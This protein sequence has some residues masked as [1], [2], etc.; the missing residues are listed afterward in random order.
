MIFIVAL[1][2]ASGCAMV[3]QQIALGLFSAAYEFLRARD[4]DAALA[5]PDTLEWMQNGGWMMGLAAG[6]LIFWLWHRGDRTLAARSNS[7]KRWTVLALGGAGAAQ[8]GYQTGINLPMP[9]DIIRPGTTMAAGTLTLFV[10]GCVVL[11]RHY[12]QG[13]STLA[14]IG[15]GTLTGM[16]AIVIIFA[17][18]ASNKYLHTLHGSSGEASAVWMEIEF[19]PNA[20]AADK[21]PDANKI[22]VA[23]RTPE[24]MASGFASEWIHNGR[25]LSLRA[26]IDLQ[27]RNRDRVVTLTPPEG[28][29]LTFRMPLPA[30]PA[31]MG[32][33]D[34]WRR[35]DF[36]G[37]TPPERHTEYRIRFMVTP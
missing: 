12:D 34:A 35:I 8:I 3:G 9:I 7:W 23:L 32:N 24:G 19:P 26:N 18:L 30:N 27:A 6:A 11:T 37:D 28:P 15:H 4:L 2:F 25:T 10:A 17:W 22:A 36:L 14:R 29:A 16:A 31:T 33:Y 1:L 20:Y 5:S 13:F 21:T